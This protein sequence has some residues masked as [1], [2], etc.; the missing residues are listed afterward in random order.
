M[1]K[2]AEKRI[3]AVFVIPDMGS[4][5]AERV[6]SVLSNCF[7]D[8]GQDVSIVY[9]LG[10]ASDYELSDGV[11]RIFFG[12]SEKNGGAVSRIKRFRRLIKDMDRRE[13]IVLIPFHDTC[14]KYCVASSAF[15][16]IPV[17]ACERNSP[18]IKGTS[19]LSRIKSNVPYMLSDRCVFQTEGA[20]EYYF[21]TVKK[22]GSVICNP[23]N[24]EAV[25]DWHGAASKTFI[26][27]GRLEPQ[28]NHE[29][30]IRAF[31]RFLK[32]HPDF[33]LEIYGEGSLRDHL[34]NLIKDL[35]AED[36]VFLCGLTKEIGK[37]LA[38]S[39]AFILSSDYE[40][41]SNALMEAL[42]CGA[43]VI[44]TDHEPG[45]ARA[46]IDHGVNGLLVPVK[47]E[48]ALTEAMEKIVSS[49]EMRLEMSRSA[50]KIRDL[51][52]TEAI[53]AKWLEVINVAKRTD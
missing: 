29:L 44:S 41:M 9:F 45:G 25:E 35:G 2:N 13:R 17:I 36:S 31:A 43:P 18:Y 33:K 28:K 3:R 6:V 40:G 19:L 39:A 1:G 32:I 26:S 4:G 16:G 50:S 53:A 52:S 51:I 23:L 48:A 42:A 46:L 10:D 8:R 22:K 37:K 7:A 11:D 27:V 21:R 49:P 15:T 12:T 30:L 20:A 38:G 14:L 47:N 34:T 24:A 5:G